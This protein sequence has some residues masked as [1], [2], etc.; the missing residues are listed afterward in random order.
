MQSVLN[1]KGKNFIATSLEYIIHN[2]DTGLWS[3]TVYVVD[4]KSQTEELLLVS[5]DIILP[6]Y[7]LNWETLTDTLNGLGLENIDKDSLKYEFS[8]YKNGRIGKNEEYFSIA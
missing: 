4:K 1:D 5:N 8:T 2:K 6:N 7:E 3:A